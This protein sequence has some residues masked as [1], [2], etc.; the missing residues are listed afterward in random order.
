MGKELKECFRCKEL[1]PS[2]HNG[3]CWTCRKDVWY[4]MHNVEYTA[5]NVDWMME[6]FSHGYLYEYE[7]REEEEVEAEAAYNQWLSG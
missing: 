6:L 5:E 2:V 4:S 3:L 1:Y 7:K